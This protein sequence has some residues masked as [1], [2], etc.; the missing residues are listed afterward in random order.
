MYNFIL[1]SDALIKLVHSGVLTKVCEAFNC[2]TTNEVERETVDEGKKRFYPDAEVIEKLIENKLSKIKNPKK[3]IEIVDRFGKGELSVLGLSKEIK[4]HI[5]I[6]DDRTFIKELEKENLDFLIPIDLIVLLKRL[7]KI[8][9]KE[10]KD[11]LEN[12]KVFIRE[13]DYKKIEKELRGK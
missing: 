1:D 4:N 12:I 7:G 13:E 2:I 6:S 11:Y 9:Q 8:N 3:D 5:I 10:A